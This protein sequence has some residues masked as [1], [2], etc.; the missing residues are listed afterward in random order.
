MVARS[1]QD[2]WAIPTKNI[3]PL[4]K[5]RPQGPPPPGQLKK[6]CQEFHRHLATVVYTHIL[7]SMCMRKKQVFFASKRKN[8][9]YFSLSFALSEYERRTLAHTSLIVTS[10]LGPASFFRGFARTTF[11]SLLEF[12]SHIRI[13]RSSQMG[14]GG[15]GGRPEQNI[16]NK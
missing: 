15:G 13:D 4:E 3:R 16:K 8:I 9:R 7:R 11:R 14:G 12:V 2:F 1:R 10:H 6:S 5:I